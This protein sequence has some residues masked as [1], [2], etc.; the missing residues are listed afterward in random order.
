MKYF[1][2]IVGGVTDDGAFLVE[3]IPVTVSAIIGGPSQT[4]KLRWI[5]R[6]TVA[7]STRAMRA[8]DSLPRKQPEPSS[9]D[10]SAMT[11][12]TSRSPRRD[13]EWSKT[14]VMTRTLM[15]GLLWIRSEPGSRRVQPDSP[16]V[17]I[18]W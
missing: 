16:P 17:Q 1:D 15:A 14:A 4:Y 10:R 11:S 12:S 8:I 5:A 2:L 7:R 6:V 9:S 18:K 13:S 3:A